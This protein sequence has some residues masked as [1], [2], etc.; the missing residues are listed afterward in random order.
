MERLKKKIIYKLKKERVEDR[1]HDHGG[2]H[3]CTDCIYNEMLEKVIKIVE[4]S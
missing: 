4:E 3:I 1:K 2:H